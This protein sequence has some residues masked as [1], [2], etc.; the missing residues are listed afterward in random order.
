MEQFYRTNYKFIKKEPYIIANEDLTE[1]GL[2]KPEKLKDF[3]LLNE[4]RRRRYEELENLYLNNVNIFY[5]KDKESY[6]PDNRIA[7]PFAKY[8]VDV[9]NGYFAGVPLKVN[10]D[11]RDDETDDKNINQAISDFWNRNSMDDSFYELSR[12][13]SIYGHSYLY[14]WQNEEAKTDTYWC[15]PKDTFVVY[16]NSIRPKALFG[17]KYSKN[18]EGNF[19]GE[20][21]MPSLKVHFSESNSTFNISYDSA[22][23]LYYPELPIIEFVENENRMGLLEGVETLINHYNKAISEKANDVDYFADAYLAVVGMELDEE[24]I[25]MLRDNRTINLYGTGT[26]KVNI[27]FLAKPNGDN[28]QENLLDR[29]ERLIY[30]TSMVVNLN[31]EKFGTTSGIA[32]ELKMQSMQNLAKTKQNKFTKGFNILF[33]NFF[34]IITNGIEANKK[35]EW[36]NLDYTFTL[37]LPKNIENEVQVARD[38]EGIVSQKTQ[39]SVLSI[40]DNVSDEI[41]QMEMENEFNRSSDFESLGFNFSKNEEKEDE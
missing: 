9:F 21:L 13:T 2:L 28:T 24:S 8:L 12:L 16:D 19:I 33:K 23:E 17:V 37:N 26:D 39:L 6:K 38:L 11:D 7:I 22:E 5:Q 10:Y 35:D 40:V 15:T 34:A 29:L 14:M 18:E 27:E 4:N 1:D 32:L 31:D 25:R 41:E 30:Q 36:I 3:I 20:L